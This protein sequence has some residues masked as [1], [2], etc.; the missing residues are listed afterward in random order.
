MADWTKQH[1]LTARFPS[2]GL[3]F[4]KG[5]S[6]QRFVHLI[7]VSTVLNHIRSCPA[8]PGLWS[9]NAKTRDKGVSAVDNPWQNPFG[10][11]NVDIPVD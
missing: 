7:H 8:E 6:H 3:P 4:F 11:M 2:D 10:S 5:S 1:S 9:E